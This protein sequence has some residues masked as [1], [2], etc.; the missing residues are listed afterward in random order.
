MSDPVEYFDGNKTF[1]PI[2]LSDF[3]ISRKDEDLY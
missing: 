1:Y 2:Y 3:P